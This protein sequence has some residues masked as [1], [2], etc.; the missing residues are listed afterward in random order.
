VTAGFAVVV[1]LLHYVAIYDPTRDP[2]QKDG[3]IPATPFRPN[4]IDESILTNLRLLLRHVPFVKNGSKK[5]SDFL[6]KVG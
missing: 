4:P 5:F 6:L 3:Q 1:I 2:S